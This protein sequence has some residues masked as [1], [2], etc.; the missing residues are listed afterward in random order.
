MKKLLFIVMFMALSLSSFVGFAYEPY[1]VKQQTYKFDANFLKKEAA[2]YSDDYR[3]FYTCDPYINPGLDGI[4][5]LFVLVIDKA[6]KTL[7]LTAKGCVWNEQEDQP[8]FETFEMPLNYGQ[9]KIMAQGNQLVTVEWEGDHYVWNRLS[10]KGKI[11]NI[12][13]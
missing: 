5:T 8:A 7:T 13:E 9:Y 4:P 1:Y 6:N 3:V 10:F 12:R 11:V 2:K